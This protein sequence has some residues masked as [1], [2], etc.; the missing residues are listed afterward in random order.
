MIVP[1]DVSVLSLC[2]VSTLEQYAVRAFS[3]ALE[4]IPLALAENSGLAPI[5][6]LAEVKSQQVREGNP[7]LGIDCLQ[8][9]TSGKQ[10]SYIEVRK[11]E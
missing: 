3:D 10:A 9:G 2:Q 6:T 7:R 1:P 11:A 4:S 8:R 5:N